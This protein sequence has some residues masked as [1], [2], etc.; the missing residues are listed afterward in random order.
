[1][2]PDA[3]PRRDTI[4]SAIGIDFRSSRW[5]RR[6]ALIGVLLWLAYEWGPG[7]ETLTP[8]VLVR[9]LNSESGVMSVMLTA[10]VGFMF[11]LCQQLASGFTA[12]VGFSMFERTA[13]ASWT[14][15]RNREA[16][17]V[18]EWAKL[19]WTARSALVFGL[20]TTAVALSQIMTTGRTGVRTHARVVAMSALLCALIVGVIGGIVATLTAIG[21]N[22]HALA[23]P[24]HQLI[25]I[26]GN[27]LVWIGFAAFILIRPMLATT[28]QS[29]DTAATV[30]STE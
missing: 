1:M 5:L 14:R 2:K 18:P 10:A 6:W 25:R 7:N 23:A 12:L 13:Q 27:P 24:T 11:T 19:G 9:V 26:L 29:D 8:Y 16:G 15:L 4:R 3:G 30:G 20:G 21:A 17:S 22:T 28:N